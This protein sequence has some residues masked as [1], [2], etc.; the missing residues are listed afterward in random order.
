MPNKW[1]W[2][3]AVIATEQLIEWIQWGALSIILYVIVFHLQTV[4]AVIGQIIPDNFTDR[5][6]HQT[7]ILPLSSHS[8][9]EQLI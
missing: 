5:D 6:I 7:L 8:Y 2:L 1:I 4:N 9:C 3:I